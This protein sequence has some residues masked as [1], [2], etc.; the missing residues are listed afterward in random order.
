MRE[1]GGRK[2]RKTESRIQ[3][4]KQ[5]KGGSRPVK[6]Y[7]FPSWSLGTSEIE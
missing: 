7:G 4:E 6:S 5:D 2:G 1:R 3:K